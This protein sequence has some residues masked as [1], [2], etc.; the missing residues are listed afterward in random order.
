LL[1][2]QQV[3]DGVASNILKWILMNA[4][5]FFNDL[6]YESI[7]FKLLT[8]GVNGVTMSHNVLLPMWNILKRSKYTIHNWCIM[9]ELQH[10]Y[11]SS[12]FL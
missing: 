9:Y 6:S 5:V 2:L 4:M 3:V 1:S 11:N 10:Q 7:T 12:N 8:F